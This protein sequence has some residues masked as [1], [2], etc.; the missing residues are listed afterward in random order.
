MD[1]EYVE[2]F[3]FHPLYVQLH[4]NEKFNIKRKKMKINFFFSFLHSLQQDFYVTFSSQIF[5]V[6][7]FLDIK[8]LYRMFHDQEFLN[9]RNH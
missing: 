3:Y 7:F 8:Q 5:V 9:I 1:V 4:P 2:E 6:L